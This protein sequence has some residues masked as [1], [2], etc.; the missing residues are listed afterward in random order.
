M[1]NE[2]IKRIKACIK[3]KDYYSA[4]EYTILIKENYINIEKQY[5][6]KIIK[7]IKQGNYKKIF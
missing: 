5:F 3:Y 4:L 7:N 1:F 2:D 6:E